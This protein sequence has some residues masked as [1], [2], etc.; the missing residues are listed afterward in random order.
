M[1]WRETKGEGECKRQVE[2]DIGEME[3]KK[4]RRVARE[5]EMKRER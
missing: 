1:G 5:R 4:G 3:R 2:S